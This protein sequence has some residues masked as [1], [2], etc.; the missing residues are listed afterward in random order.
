MIYR[1]PFY[2]KHIDTTAVT[3][4][5]CCQKGTRTFSVIES[6]LTEKNGQSRSLN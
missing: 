1:G 4:A 6:F 3:D 5:E 2:L